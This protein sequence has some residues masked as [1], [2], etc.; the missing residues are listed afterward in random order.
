MIAL[1]LV[2]LLL[3]FSSALTNL[4]VWQMN[5]NAWLKEKAEQQSS[6]YIVNLRSFI[7]QK[8]KKQSKFLVNIKYSK[9]SI[10]NVNR[11]A[12]KSDFLKDQPS[13][14]LNKFFSARA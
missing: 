6:Y 1:L 3:H 4:L 11:S 2:A 5:G 10:R 12:G 9:F 13:L 8:K 7:K 14:D